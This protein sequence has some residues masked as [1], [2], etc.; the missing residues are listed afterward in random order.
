MSQILYS[1]VGFTVEMAGHIA[2]KDTKKW[3]RVIADRYLKIGSKTDDQVSVRCPENDA[4]DH[5]GRTLHGT[6]RRESSWG[7]AFTSEGD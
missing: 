6:D 5:S 1:A 4:L 2:R 3:T 7:E